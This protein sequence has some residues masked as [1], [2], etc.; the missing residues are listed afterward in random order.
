M[1]HCDWHNMWSVWISG[2]AALFMIRYCISCHCGYNCRLR[3]LHFGTPIFCHVTLLSRKS[4]MSRSQW[5]HGLSHDPSSSA[6]TLGSWVPIPL[7]AWM[8][9]CVYSVCV[10][11]GLATGWPPFQGVLPTVYRIKKLEKC[12]RSKG[13][14]NHREGERKKFYMKHDSK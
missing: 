4:R 1:D 11:S 5:P 14:Q 12:P 3:S 13:L 2:I 6:G 9:V 8:S 10:G 7:E